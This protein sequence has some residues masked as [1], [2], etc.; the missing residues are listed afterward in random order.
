MTKGGAKSKLIWDKSWQN[1]I[2]YL[3]HHLCLEQVLTLIDLQ[4]PFEIN[5]YALDYASNSILTQHGNLIAYYNETLFDE[6]HRYTTYD[7]EM[8]STM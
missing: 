8:Y 2:A 4:Q 6:V 5:T 3:K 7:K 1:A